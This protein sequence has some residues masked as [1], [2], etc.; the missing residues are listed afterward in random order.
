MAFAVNDRDVAH[1]VGLAQEE[2][3]RLSCAVGRMAYHIALRRFLV[4]TDKDEVGAVRL[5]CADERL[6]LVSHLS[7]AFE[8]VGAQLVVLL[9]HILG[10]EIVEHGLCRVTDDGVVSGKVGYGSEDVLP[11]VGAERVDALH[12]AVEATVTVDK[13]RR[14]GGCCERC[15]ARA[16]CSIDDDNDG[17]LRCDLV[18]LDYWHD[19][20]D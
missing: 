12:G 1:L 9:A 18:F 11:C 19:V 17:A 7:E 14:V 4:M 2:V 3:F 15:L 5:E 8:R 13:D 10:E 6:E 20:F 16:R